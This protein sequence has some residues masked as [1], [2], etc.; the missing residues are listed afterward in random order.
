MHA[1]KAHRV[2]PGLEGGGAFA[3]TPSAKFIFLSASERKLT[4]VGPHGIES[5]ALPHAPL[6]LD[7]IVVSHQTGSALV[8][9]R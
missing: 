8:S 1:Y 6:R 3:A 2:P 5:L 9:P 4:A 7:R